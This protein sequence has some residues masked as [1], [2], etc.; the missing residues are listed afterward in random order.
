MMPQPREPP[1]ST[2]LNV[3]RRSGTLRWGPHLAHQVFKF[4]MVVYC[5]TPGLHQRVVAS[6]PLSA[7]SDDLGTYGSRQHQLHAQ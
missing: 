2:F 5:P 7:M 4:V 6:A 3:S 1:N